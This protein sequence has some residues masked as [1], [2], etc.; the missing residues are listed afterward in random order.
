MKKVIAVI[1]AI[2]MV[3]SLVACGAAPSNNGNGSS[4]K[5]ETTIEDVQQ[6]Y[7]NQKTVIN[8][9]LEDY[10]K[11]VNGLSSVSVSSNKFRFGEDL[12]WYDCHYTLNFSCK[13]NGVNHIGEARAFVKYQDS[14]IHWF[15]FEIFS[16]D[17]YQSVV[18]EYDEEYDQ[19]IE[20]Y[21]HELQDKYK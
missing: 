7:N 9:S 11:S 14:E 21:Y 10:A 5:E 20:D 2:G 16:N 18:E 8:Q 19:I 3:C 12:G 17:S 4:A 15:H 13:I 1:L 6:W